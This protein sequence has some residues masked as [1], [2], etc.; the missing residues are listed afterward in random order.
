MGKVFKMLTLSPFEPLHKTLKYL[1]LKTVF[2]TAITTFRRCS[3]LQS[4]RLG[5]GNVTVHSEGI[6]F[7]RQLFPSRTD[8]H[9]W[10]EIFGFRRSKMARN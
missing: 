6:M 10:E 3:D 2:F 1:T 5:E 7:L 9:T 4:L 8:D